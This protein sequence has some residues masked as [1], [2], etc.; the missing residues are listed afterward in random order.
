MGDTLEDVADTL[1][2]L[3]ELETDTTTT[4]KLIT[5][6][7]E[8]RTETGTGPVDWVNGG[9]ICSTSPASV[10]HGSAEITCVATTPFK[11]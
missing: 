5:W 7:F 10:I 8:K 11:V 4:W 3:D 6:P 9:A 2:V 1:D